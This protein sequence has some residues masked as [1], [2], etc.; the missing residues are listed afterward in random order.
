MAFFAISIFVAVILILGIVGDMSEVKR[1]RKLLFKGKTISLHTF[2]AALIL[3]ATGTVS[4]LSLLY[5]TAGGGIKAFLP[6]SRYTLPFVIA[7]MLTSLALI[8]AGY[9]IL[10][11][12]KKQL[13]VFYSC[14]GVTILV[15]VAALLSYH[16][17]MDNFG[18]HGFAALL[19]IA[20]GIFSTVLY[21]AYLILL[22]PEAQKPLTHGEAPPHH[23]KKSA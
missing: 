2:A 21:T 9:S 10:D 3:I 1:E 18:L 22:S 19:Q 15:S 8:A 5:F 14:V 12:W 7:Q 11:S 17:S 16:G 23:R 13:P 6:I 20:G 4:F